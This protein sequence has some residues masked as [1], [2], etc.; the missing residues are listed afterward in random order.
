MSAKAG[1]EAIN[2]LLFEYIPFIKKTAAYICKRP[3]NQQDEEYSIALEGFHEALLA[4][5]NH[6]S[7]SLETFAHLVMKRRL[8][9]FLRKES[10]RKEILVEDGANHFL[11]EEQSLQQF[12][13]E[14]QIDARREEL[15]KY[16]EL[17]AEYK[18]SFEELTKAAPKHADSRKTAFQVAQIISESEELYGSFI[19]KKKLPLKDIEALVGVSRKT[20]ERHR[21]YMIA[22]VLLLKSDFVYI[23]EYVKGEII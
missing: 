18:L 15:V 4:Y 7:A 11:L 16:R 6:H 1:E 17:L 14:E 8:I 2:D 23:K 9:D 22:V 12:S 20:L 13:E 21:K 10:S 5:R 19:Q 3:I